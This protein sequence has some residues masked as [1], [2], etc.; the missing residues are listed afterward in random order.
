MYRIFSIKHRG[1]GGN[2]VFVDSIISG[3]GAKVI[4]VRNIFGAELTEPFN[5]TR[6]L[7]FTSPPTV[8]FFTAVNHYLNICTTAINGP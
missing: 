7:K 6:I 8:A 3:P 5:N 1:I 4:L 2:L